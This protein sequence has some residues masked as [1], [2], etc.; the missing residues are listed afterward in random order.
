MIF[1]QN[2]ENKIKV[3]QKF[4]TTL[5]FALSG[6]F[7]QN[8]DKFRENLDIFSTQFFRQFR[9]KLEQVGSLMPLRIFPPSAHLTL[10]LAFFQYV[11][12]LAPYSSCWVEPWCYLKLSPLSTA[13][14]WDAGQNSWQDSN[15]LVVYNTINNTIYIVSSLVPIYLWSVHSATNQFSAIRLEVRTWF[16]WCGR[17]QN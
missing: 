14:R 12:V 9:Q 7:S 5:D 17:R 6:T 4:R 15:K 2:L 1:R 8:L 16:S 13:G 3:R 10:L 11:D